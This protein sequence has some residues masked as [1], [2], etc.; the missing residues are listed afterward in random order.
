[1][2]ERFGVE[3][4]NPCKLNHSPDATYEQIMRTDISAL[5]LCDSVYFMQDWRLSKS[6]MQEMKM[7]LEF[8]IPFI[9]EGIDNVSGVMKRPNISNW[10]VAKNG[11]LVENIKI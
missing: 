10:A 1:M 5:L 7:C 3:V 11:D 8:R 9:I 6:A 4:I 2:I